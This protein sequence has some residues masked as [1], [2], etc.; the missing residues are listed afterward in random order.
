[1]SPREGGSSKQR[2]AATKKERYVTPAKKK[3]IAM[4][5]CKEENWLRAM[6]NSGNRDEAICDWVGNGH[7]GAAKFFCCD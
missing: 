2:T 5:F 3:W 1:M 7:A 4:D 6:T